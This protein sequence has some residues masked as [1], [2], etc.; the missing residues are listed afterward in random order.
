MITDVS[1]MSVEQKSDN[2]VTNNIIPLHLNHY[3]EHFQTVSKDFL[4]NYC[5]CGY[6]KNA[7]TIIHEEIDKIKLKF[8]T[9]T[10]IEV[11]N[12]I[13]TELIVKNMKTIVEMENC[14]VVYM[15][16][17]NQNDDLKWMYNFLSS[18]NGG[19]KVMFDGMRPYFREIGKSVV[20]GTN[21]NSDVNTCIQ[22]LLDL[23]RK[24]NNLKVNLFNNDTLFDEIV[25][26]EFNYFLEFNPLVPEYLSFFI[27]EKL[28]KGKHT[29]IKNNPEADIDNVIYM[30]KYLKNKVKFEQ[31]YRINLT[32]RLLHCKSVSM[33]NENKMISK[34]EN[35][36]ANGYGRLLFISKI[37]GMVKDKFV[38]SKT[39]MSNYKQCAN[40]IKCI[41][42][43]TE[44]Y[45][46]DLNVQVL[47]SINW[48]VDP[49]TMHEIPCFGK[50]VFDEF[51]KLY[52]KNNQ[53]GNNKKLILLPQF[54]TVELNAIF[55]GK[56]CSPKKL[57][58]DELPSISEKRDARKLKITV[59]TNQMQVLDLFNAHNTLTF[60]EIQIKTKIPRLSLINAL[61]DMTT[62]SNHLQHLLVK[63]P[64]GEEIKLTDKFN[65]NETFQC[66]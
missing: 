18:V 5:A 59:S 52:K 19:V 23:K 42:G 34:L 28:R 62:S 60:N 10:R 26:E 41:L 66:I 51:Q 17:N 53:S 25:G 38:L 8:D 32:N 37:K 35:A 30:I 20:L 58:I 47:T 48:P 12:I 1:K 36:Y 61:Q 4:F 29:Y 27:D 3:T 43:T 63:V 44:S 2:N 11:V 50:T 65:V 40:V 13:K 22:S 15:L 6:F 39:I 16:K 46:F 55:Y 56:P 7:E 54:G 21:R 57:F 64:M 14:G 45:A 33:D 24:F 49:K 31:F 9:P